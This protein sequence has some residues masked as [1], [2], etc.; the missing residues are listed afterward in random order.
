MQLDL[1]MSGTDGFELALRIES[2]PI[3]ATTRLV[4][5]TLDGQWG[6]G[7]NTKARC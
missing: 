6:D 3:L 5:L 2:D 1:M 4:M 7:K